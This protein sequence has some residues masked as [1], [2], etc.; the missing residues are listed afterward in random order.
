MDSMFYPQ[1]GYWHKNGMKNTQNEWFFIIFYPPHSQI[2]NFS[3]LCANFREKQRS[4][5][6]HLH[7]YIWTEHMN[8]KRSTWLR[9]LLTL[10][11]PY[12]LSAQKS[13]YEEIAENCGCT[14]NRVYEIAHGAKCK[15]F[16]DDAAL[17]E[18][19]RAG[20]VKR[21]WPQKEETDTEE[22]FCLCGDDGEGYS[23]AT[24]MSLNN[25]SYFFLSST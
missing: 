16:V 12:K 24:T 9:C 23:P 6:R 14:P 18:L 21:S 8:L 4:S 15:S 7:D 11:H 2:E 17:S 13:L 19:K 5:D 22:G 10:G 20:I 3:Y 25:L 1:I